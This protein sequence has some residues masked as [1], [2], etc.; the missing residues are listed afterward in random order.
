MLPDLPLALLAPLVVLAA[1]TVYGISG[2]GSALVS[3]PLLAHLLP[4]QT[5]VPMVLLLDFSAALLMGATL[6]GEV[7]RDELRT[8]LPGIVIGVVAGVVLLSRAPGE[9]LLIPLGVFVAGFSALNLIRRGRAVRFARPWGYVAGLLGGLLGALFG[10]GGPMYATYFAGRLDDP[11]RV[12]A[13][14]S[15]VF[16]VSTAL[17]IALL[18][19]VGLL[20]RKDVWIGAAALLP[21]VF[22][23]T[24]IG[25]NLHGRVSPPVLVRVLNGLLLASG[26]SL[27]ARGLARI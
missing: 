12:R 13:T 5:V 7:A 16:S 10:V 20:L 6:R 3:I 26:L 18:L 25:R 9:S 11:S 14:L 21:F 24:R 4:L 19:A 23:G 27:V 22:V 15:V 2:F 8:V 17:R 1:Y